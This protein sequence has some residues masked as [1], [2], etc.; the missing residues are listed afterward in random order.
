MQVVPELTDLVENLGKETWTEAVH[1][2]TAGH[3]VGHRGVARDLIEQIHAT[4]D[5]V[6]GQFQVPPLKQGAWMRKGVYL[7]GQSLPEPL[8]DLRI[9]GCNSAGQDADRCTPVDGLESFKDW[10]KKLFII[11]CPTH[12]VDPQCY[13]GLD[14]FLSHPLGRCQPRQIQVRVKWA[15]VFEMDKPVAGTAGYMCLSQGWKAQQEQE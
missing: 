1:R 3:A 8:L 7:H 13:H 9:I 14:P 11:G 6:G 15:W 2:V 12:V 4:V 10:S 5:G